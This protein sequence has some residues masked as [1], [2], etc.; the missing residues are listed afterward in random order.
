MRIALI[1]PYLPSA[2]N[3]NA[4][5]ATRWRRF[6]RA[7][8]HTVEL[9]LEWDG[10]AVDLMIALHARRSHASVARYA[11]AHPDRPLVLV[12]TGT[13][14]YRDIAF[15]A[16]AQ[17]SLESASGL[18]VLQERGP[19]ALPE[20]LRGK[21]RVIFQ[22][23]PVLSTGVK[24]A[25]HFEVCVVS[26]LREEKDPFRAAFASR[27]L[28][29]HSRIRVRHVGGPLAPG[30][31]GQ[32]QELAAACPRWDWLGPRTHGETRRF[33]ARS[34]L[35]VLSSRM[36]GGANVICEAVMAGT[37]VLASRI[38]GNVGMLG[39]DY[40]GYFP[41]GD[42]AALAGLMARA[43]SD[44]HFYGRLV[45]QCARRT[46]LFDPA[47]EAAAVRGLVEEGRCA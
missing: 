43:E 45:A 5:T 7:A 30:M 17:D 46:H 35:L 10:R 8:R 12:L 39:A 4:H 15:D 26:H 42:E 22:S 29:E 32:A 3:G 31:A 2:R 25:R 23:A 27:L 37:P 11:A 14:L 21:T 36:E 13:D 38:E 20:H 44:P 34:H 33:M 24:N 47:R 40:A 41:V 28:P 1:T 16:D 6:L 19:S 9:G 18:V